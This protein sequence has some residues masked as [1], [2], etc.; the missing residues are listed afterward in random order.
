MDFLCAV[1]SNIRESNDLVG[2]LLEL[3]I[4]CFGRI[5]SAMPS[6]EEEFI[7]TI[8]KSL[9]DEHDKMYQMLNNFKQKRLLRFIT[10]LDGILYTLNVS[11]I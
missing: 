9:N 7:E 2:V 6:L 1:L 4:D 5:K 8:K 10:K 3:V 11:I